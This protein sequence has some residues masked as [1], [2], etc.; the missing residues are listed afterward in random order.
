LK[1][2]IAEQKEIYKERTTYTEYFDIDTMMAP[3]INAAQQLGQPAAWD[4]PSLY[5]SRM[6]SG[7]SAESVMGG[8]SLPGTAVWTQGP[9]SAAPLTSAP[10]PPSSAPNHGMNIVSPPSSLQRGASY[11]SLHETTLWAGRGMGTDA[12][13]VQYPTQLAAPVS[14]P[15]VPPVE[16]GYP[17]SVNASSQA[18]TQQM[19]VSYGGQSPPQMGFSTWQG[20][21]PAGAGLPP[22]QS[23]AVL[24]SNQEWYS[25]EQLQYEQAKQ[26]EMAILA[27]QEHLMDQT[28][29][30]HIRKNG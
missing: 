4:E 15:L 22:A 26:Q 28:M 6:Q 23:Q 11:G 24:G 27:S 29:P 13:G 8:A 1:S 20:I 7:I 16:G 14:P 3:D 2:Q 5:S 25:V 10:A 21:S 30:Y 9:T 18:I 19:A 12:A 17:P